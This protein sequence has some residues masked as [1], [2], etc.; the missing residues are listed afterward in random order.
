MKQIILIAL[1]LGISQVVKGQGQLTMY[2]NI[3]TV[4]DEIETATRKNINLWNKDL[5]GAIL[6]VDPQTR[7]LFANELDTAGILKPDESIYTGILP[8]NINIANTA[9]EWNGKSWAMIMLP[10]P[11]NKYERIDLLAH[12]SFHREQSSLGFKLN[13]PDNNHLDLKE[14]RIY[15]RLELEALKSAIES[16]EE[17]ILHH[18]TSALIFRKYRNLL[19]PGIDTMENQLELNEGIATFTGLIISGRDE[20]QAKEHIA[21]S[22]NTFF[23][24]PTYVRSFAYN[25][26]PAYGY[27]LYNKDKKWNK[28]ITATTDLTAFFTEAFN[29]NWPTDLQKTI[30]IISDEYQSSRFMGYFDSRKR[31]IN[32]S[33]LE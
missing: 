18:L 19:Y 29:I 22:I 26:T 2:D 7:Q 31:S 23:T 8:E 16:S 4:F 3:S 20:K 9:I 12:E 11:E 25:T 27:L 10:L 24:N 30:D 6:L 17:E 15:L 13:N 32:E 1:L 21:N 5:Y 28:Q 14:G 33:P